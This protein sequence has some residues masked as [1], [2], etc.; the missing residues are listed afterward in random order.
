MRAFASLYERIDATT[1]TNAKVQ[2]MV[3]YFQAAPPADAAWALYFLTGRRMKRFVSSRAIRA[4]T[5]Q[6]TGIED[7]LFQESYNSVGDSA[8]T[9]ALLLDSTGFS[10]TSLASDE[11]LASWMNSKIIPLIGQDEDVQKQEVISW[12]KNSDR[13]EIFILNKLL[14]GALRVGVSQSLVSRALAKIAGVETAEISHRLMGQWEA[15]PEWYA[16]LL[17]AEAGSRSL[18]HPYP[19]FLASPLEREAEELGSPRE[20]Q[21]EWKWDGIRAQLIRRGGEV[22][23]WSRGEELITDRFPEITQAALKLPD[24]TVLDG[25]IL[26]MKG[27]QVLPF[28]ILQKRIGR[29]KLSKGILTEAPA[30][31]M[32]YDL[33]EENGTELRSA[34]LKDR[35]QRLENLIE[36]K[37]PFHLSPKIEFASWADLA[38]RRKES[39]DRKVEGIMLKRLSSSYQAGRK[40]GDWWKWKIDPLTVDTVLIYAQAGSGRRANLFTDYTFAVWSGEQLVPVAKAYSGLS[41]E[42]IAKLDSWVRRNTKD[43]FGPVRSVTPQHVFE[44]AFEGINSSPRHKSGVALRFPRILRWRTDKKIQDADTLETLQALIDSDERVRHEKASSPQYDL[45]TD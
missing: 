39:R 24:G 31:F 22:F 42:E 36:G 29:T 20:W 37:S 18:S 1:S 17:N 27:E 23:L 26:A 35:R 3:D 13:L 25:E 9:C 28:G 8:E 5:L 34:T 14:T 6:L 12:W 19:F 16:S 30:G 4:W 15:T 33:I 38:N 11:S 43:R 44:I 2:A 7:W 10:R 45:A 32:I 40:R 21:A 41:D